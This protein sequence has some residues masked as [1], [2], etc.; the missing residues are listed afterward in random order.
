MATTN[1]TVERWGR[2]ELSLSG[3]AE[4]NPFLDTIFS[5]IF[6]HDAQLVR[7][8]GFYDGDGVYRARFMPDSLGVWRYQTSSNRP[9]LDGQAGAFTCVAPNPGNHGPVRVAGACHFTYADG[10]PYRPV[11]TTCYVWTLQ[12]EALEQQT[13][14]TLKRAPFNK[15][16]FCVFPKRFPYNEGEPP[17]YPFPGEVRAGAAPHFSLGGP[18]EPPPDYWDF[19]RFTPAYF[20]HLEQ[21]IADLGALG[22]EADLILFHPYDFGAW[23]FDRMPAEVN[24]RYLRYIVARL[25]AYRNVWWSF[26]NEYEMLVDHSMA[27]WDAHFQLVQQI[28]PVGHLRSIH[29]IKDFYDHRKP[30]VTHCSIQ[31][32]DTSRAVEWQR[33]YGK[34]VVIDECGYEGDLPMSW[35][36]LTPQETVQRF[37]QGFADGC[38]VGHG[39]TY[40]NPEGIL[41]WS[42]GGTLR[43]ESVARIAFLRDV[44]E[45]VPGAS[46]VPLSPLRF[47]A[48]ASMAD[49]RAAFATPDETAAIVGGFAMSILAG[50]HSGTDY[51][52]FYFGPH[53]P[54]Y[55]D[56]ELPAGAFKIDV[57]DT[58][59]M[60]VTCA[61]AHASG[62]VRVALPTKPYQAIRIERTKP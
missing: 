45:A 15:L 33:Q 42:K 14:E 49:V 46:L 20:Q 47:G 31:H 58:W 34:P 44:I 24:E 25:A 9:E 59:D 61:A 29:N 50:G 21:R 37:W 57:L 51:Y 11:G 16:R 38:Y 36:D 30:W 28:D 5:V 55:Q 7:V 40:L 22:I 19:S 48:M 54:A 12:G 53:Q 26:A 23:G 1:P 13:L 3:L 2:F 39:E 27:D 32:S 10:T 56:Y 18:T 60:T 43:G 52:L 4:G 8:D 35:G 17:C 62:H 41:W 6:S